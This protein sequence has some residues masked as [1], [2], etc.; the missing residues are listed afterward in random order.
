MAS[1]S[2][3][4]YDNNMNVN[5]SDLVIISLNMHG[6]N[7]G[8]VTIKELIGHGFPDLLML[9][10]H[11][12]TPTNL[13]RFDEFLPGYFKFGSSAMENR[14]AMGP[15]YGRPFGGMMMLI[16]NSLYQV[17]ECVYLAERCVIIRIAN[18]LCINVYFPCVGTP[19][20]LLILQD[21]IADINSWIDNFP[22]C[23]VL[24]GGDFNIDLDSNADISLYVNDF[25][26]QRGLTRC[27]KIMP[28]LMN[29]TFYDEPN[30]HRSY[31]DY[32]MISDVKDVV[33]FEVLD[34]D[35]NPSDHLPIRVTC[36]CDLNMT[37]DKAIQDGVDSDLS[38][39]QMRWDHA[40]LT[41]Y[42]FNTLLHL[43]PLFVQ[44]NNIENRGFDRPIDD[45]IWE[46]DNI[47]MNI[48]NALNNS[49]VGV[50]PLHKKGFYKYWWC[51]TLDCLKE[52][53]IKSCQLWKT[54]G[55]PRS[56]HIFQSYQA[57]K[58][59]YKRRIRQGQREEAE[60]YTNE[61][62]D[63]L[64][65]KSGKTFWN[66][67]KSKF[68]N[69]NNKKHLIQVDGSVDSNIIAN[70]FANYFE[71]ACSN[72]SI[73]RSSELRQLYTEKRA[74]YQGLPYTDELQFDV[75]LL[76]NVVSNLKRGKAAGLDKLN[77]EHLQNS[78]PILICILTKLFNLFMHYGHVPPSFG[79]S[80]TVPLVKDNAAQCKVLTTKDF[81]GISISP[82]ISKAFEYCILDR[83]KKYLV[84][85][86]NQFG[87]KKKL[88]CAHA[89]Y[90]VR[91]VVDH[92]VA[93]G[94]TVNICAIDLSKAFDKTNHHGLFIKLM[95]RNIPLRLLV[96]LETWLSNCFTCVKWGTKISRF[97]QL[98][99][100]VRQGG[101]L[102]PYLFALYIDD[103][104]SK[105]NT[106]SV[107]CKILSCN[108][109]I[110]MY[111]DDIL[112]V[113]PSIHGLQ[114]LLDVCEN[115][116]TWLDM[117]INANKS[118]CLRIGPR[119]NATC[120]KLVTTNGQKIEWATTC[121]YLGVFIKSSRT[122]RCT[123][124]HARKKF[125]RAFN[126]IYGKIGNVASEEVIIKLI[127]SKCMPILTYGLQA[128]P[129]NNRERKSLDFS[130][131]RIFMKMF[132]T[133][134]SMIIEECQAF[135]GFLPIR[136]LIDI[137]K[138]N[139]LGE[140]CDSPNFICSDILKLFASM[141]LI[142]ICNKYSVTNYRQIKT[143][144]YSTFFGT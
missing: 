130:V 98:N 118:V 46:L 35:I 34:P 16:K 76:D 13:V 11:W 44:V 96:I 38:I 95:N 105:V 112:L 131:N 139:F 86:D 68:N 28:R 32:F 4:L 93:G 127:T 129:I 142:Q 135:L 97:F 70:N 109:S 55:K 137:Y 53:A 67:W 141:E 17:T 126:A 114:I 128:C 119:F 103:I 136:L 49:A 77:V 102:S 61:L 123:F 21:L 87:F 73:E 41:S 94:S 84:T 30:D 29:Y 120:A 57:E 63:A 59:A 124:D 56:G 5:K 42:Y 15:L 88:S 19:D 115:E 8:V 82:V 54:A 140:L 72:F 45:I 132:K 62:H 83:Y 71:Q 75:N 125:Y 9:Q 111:A 100:G 26:D 143:K 66:C 24:L 2:N 23:T 85:S 104:V 116:L 133:S 36:Q 18:I 14:V 27:D 43:Q 99:A 12:L 25:I 64:I 79:E 113:A 51:Q 108:M 121:R 31:I 81:R 48:V 89:I 90:S 101:V 7:Q 47:Y 3:S 52:S 106:L 50:V 22:T 138:A 39:I 80:Y 91:S 107:G 122:F 117:R 60:N 1:V 10:E 78:H 74:V 58:L 40:D 110:F 144:I 92:Y 6:Y 69:N 37:C 20:R 134:S 65:Q 33:R